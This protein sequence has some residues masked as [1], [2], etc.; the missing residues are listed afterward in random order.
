MR[1]YLLL[2]IDCKQLLNFIKYIFFLNDAPLERYFE[3]IHK[4]DINIV[5]SDDYNVI[6]KKGD[7]DE[8]K[9][10][11]SNKSVKMVDAVVIVKFE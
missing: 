11:S 10:F 8:M 4:T 3:V 6:A 9:C 1:Q 2:S 5:S 7:T